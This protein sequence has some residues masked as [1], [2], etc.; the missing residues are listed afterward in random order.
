M[1]KFKNWLWNKL[2]LKDRLQLEA[3]LCHTQ[4]Q[5]EYTKTQLQIAKLNRLEAKVSEFS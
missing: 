1:D 2:G 3:E 5:L 4:Q